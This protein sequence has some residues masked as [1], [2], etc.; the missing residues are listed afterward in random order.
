MLAIAE[1]LL[2]SARHVV[3]TSAQI[4]KFYSVIP[5]ASVLELGR[6]GTFSANIQIP[7]TQDCRE[8]V[9]FFPS[10]LRQAGKNYIFSTANPEDRTRLLPCCFVSPASNTVPTMWLQLWQTRIISAHPHFRCN[11]LI[12]R[13]EPFNAQLMILLL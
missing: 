6:D 7:H 1:W 10:R 13:K 4:V 9:R 5:A 8:N 12:L 11:I 3:R 2:L